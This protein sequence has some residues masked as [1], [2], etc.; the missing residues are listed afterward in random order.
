MRADR[1]ASELAARW[2][3]PPEWLTAASLHVE[4]LSPGQY[5]AVLLL[6]AVS[7]EPQLKLG[8]TTHRVIRAP[9]QAT[10]LAEKRRR[11]WAAQV[12]G[13]SHVR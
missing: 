8:L 12:T 7:V 5:V 13:S 1:L 2:G 4:E 9:R 11:R 6:P 3:V 10:Q